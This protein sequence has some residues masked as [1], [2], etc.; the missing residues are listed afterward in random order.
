M[1]RRA[2][3]HSEQLQ[4][5][6]STISYL[7]LFPPVFFGFDLGDVVLSGRCCLASLASPLVSAPSRSFARVASNGSS[8]SVVSF[9]ETLSGLSSRSASFRRRPRPLRSDGAFEVFTTVF[10]SA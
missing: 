2:R 5:G 10:C 6:P 7:R 1:K 4:S 3:R 9:C 8:D